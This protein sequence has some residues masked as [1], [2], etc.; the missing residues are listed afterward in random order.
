MF[1]PFD[2]GQ[3]QN[4]SNHFFKKLAPRFES[5][6][7]EILSQLAKSASQRVNHARHAVTYEAPTLAL[8]T[9]VFF[10]FLQLFGP[11]FAAISLLNQRR[12]CSFVVV[13]TD[14]LVA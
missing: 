12:A 1:R 6:I 3:K 11:V 10:L 2:A 14:G 4:K 8:F 13:M 5:E 9:G 7:Q